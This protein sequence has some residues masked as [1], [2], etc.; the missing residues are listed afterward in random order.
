MW[1]SMA[2]PQAHAEKVDDEQKEDEPEVK[3]EGR[4]T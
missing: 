1:T 2:P 4:C 3:E